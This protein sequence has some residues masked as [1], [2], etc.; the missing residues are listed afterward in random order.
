M[1]TGLGRENIAHLCETLN[2]PFSMAKETWNT[3]E[4]VLYDAHVSIIK[5]ELA[6]NRNEARLLAVEELG[7]ED[8]D[9]ETVI[10]IAISF[11]GTVRN[12]LTA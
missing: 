4:S 10:P 1:Q 11:D 8:V 3:H 7:T 6:K 2:I 12:V 9:E 5:K